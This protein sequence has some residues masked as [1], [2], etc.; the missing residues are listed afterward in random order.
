MRQWSIAVVVSLAFLL[1]AAPPA[2]VQNVL[3]LAIVSEITG[4]GAPSG[5][6][7]RD[8]VNLAVDDVNAHGGILGQHVETAVYDTQSDPAAA[9]AA[10][11]RAIDDH[12]FAVMGA[13]YSSSTLAAMGLAQQAGILEIS[14]S[15]SVD[16]VGKGNPDIFLTSFSQRVGMAKLVKWL[17]Q[18]LNA[19]KIALIYVN[20]AFGKGGH[21]T[22]VSLLKTRGLSPVADISTEVQQADFTPELLRVRNSGATHLMIYSHE[23]ENARIMIQLRKLGLTVAPVGDNLCNQTTIDAGG[24]AV[25]GSRCHVS[26]TAA[27]SPLHSMVEA[28]R[29]FQAKYGKIPDANGLKGYIGV[30]MLRAAAAR[31][32]APDQAK[33]RDCLHANLLTAAEEPGLLED[34]YVQPNGDID[35]PSF[36]V[37]VEN[38]KTAVF[39]VVPMLAGPYTKRACR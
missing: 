36:I 15:E 27:E 30:Y 33:I 22:F 31:A 5:T 17:V 6:M 25:S 9:V 13:V 28:G 11:R 18:D 20:D 10:M 4:G 35:R 7:W 21:D 26:M 32:G 12:P 14:G 34:M 23:E 29:R 38:G 8:G 37:Q 39:T 3:R 24:D 19:R 2:S 1:A 16:V